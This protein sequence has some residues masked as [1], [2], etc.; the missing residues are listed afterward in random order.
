MI[1]LINLVFFPGNAV[2]NFTPGLAQTKKCLR[3]AA[4]FDDSTIFIFVDMINEKLK[5]Y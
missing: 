1:L 2:G 4:D 5:Y 3:P